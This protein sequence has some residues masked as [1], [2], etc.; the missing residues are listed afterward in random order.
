MSGSLVGRV[1]R[2]TV[3]FLSGILAASALTG[4]VAA[5]PSVRPFATQ[6]RDFSCMGLAF[7][8]IDDQTAGDW[9]DNMRIR[10]SEIGDG[11][12]VCNAVLPDRAVV[13]QVS[14]ALYDN[15]VVGLIQYCGL[16]R[17]GLTASTMDDPIQGLASVSATSMAGK[18]GFVRKSTS[19]ISRATIDNA[20]YAYY[21]QCQIAFDENAFSL[22][23]GILGATVTY[24][25]SSTNG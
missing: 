3:L 16:D 13:E 21:L 6:T 19:G 9:Q 12:F 25:I 15:T 20:S 17:K 2:A 14:F 22:G 7:E 8:P 18:P 11:F 1:S 10:R 23:V 4:S 5:A 24:R